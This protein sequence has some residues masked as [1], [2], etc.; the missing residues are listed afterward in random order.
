IFG[1]MA[2]AGLS[3]YLA[4]GLRRTGAQLEE[5]STQL[6]DLQAFN[7]HVIDSLRSGLATTDTRGRVLTF[8][9][10][11]ESITGLPA[12]E[13]VG[14]DVNEVLQLP[15]IFKGLFTAGG[16]RSV[17]P[18]QEFGHHRADG[19]H[20]ELGLTSAPLMTPRG[21]SGFLFT[22]QDVTEVKKQEREAR[23]QQRLAAVGEMAAGI[24]HEIR[25]PLASM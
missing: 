1:F 21:E 25:N 22:F 23:V 20:I 12:A 8:N 13:A 9:H 5:A 11:A 24:A 7:Q 10:A 18:R 16:P 17:S 4:E 14:C 19:R 15:A 3:S 6:A 2:V